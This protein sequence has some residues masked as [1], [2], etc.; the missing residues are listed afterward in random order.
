MRTA[1]RPARSD[2]F[3]FCAALYFHGMDEIIREL[4]LD[5]AR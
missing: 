5:I 3:D 4:K 1:L 2:D